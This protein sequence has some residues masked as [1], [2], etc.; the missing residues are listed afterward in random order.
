M[1]GSGHV[2]R[3]SYRGVSQ[4][5]VGDEV[6]GTECAQG[7]ILRGSLGFRRDSRGLLLHGTPPLQGNLQERR[8]ARTG[9]QFS[10]FGTRHQH[11]RDYPLVSGFR[12]ETRTCTRGRRDHLCDRDRTPHAVHL[13]QG[14]RSAPRGRAALHG[15]D[16]GRRQEAL[17][18]G[19]LH[20][21]HG[22]HT[23][24][25]KLGI[26]PGN[27]CG[28]GSSL[29]GKILHYRSFRWYSCLV[30]FQLVQTKRAR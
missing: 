10:L 24:L 1:S 30:D 29:P 26:I 23:H 3:G 16:G 9:R 11:N 7:C 5:A 18:D 4:Q 21:L 14:R 27:I 19:R 8:R 15:A 6:S 12:L 17:A 28:M 25:C 2:H 22:R 13:S 20:R